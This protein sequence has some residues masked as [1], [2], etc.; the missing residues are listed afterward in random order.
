MS[1]LALLSRVPSRRGGGLSDMDSS[2]GAQK[3]VQA[4]VRKKKK[5]QQAPIDTVRYQALVDQLDR[6]SLEAER[7]QSNTISALDQAMTEIR[8][9]QAQVAALQA[10]QGS[11]AGNL[12]LTTSRVVTCEVTLHQHGQQ[13][14]EVQ[15]RQ[16][17]MSS[18]WEAFQQK[19]K[20]GSVGMGGPQQ[21]AG[22]AMDFF[23]HPSASAI[24]WPPRPQ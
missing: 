11:M 20:D 5:R 1:P 17:I 16:N 23:L 8:A 3:Q 24:P 10:A 2:E 9:L 15:Q 13:L 7:N 12:D 19:W 6:T 22:H 4:T 21:E 18:Q 14:Q